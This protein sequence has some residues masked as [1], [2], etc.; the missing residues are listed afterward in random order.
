MGG[1]GGTKGDGNNRVGGVGRSCG[2]LEDGEGLW[3]GEDD[4]DIEGGIGSRG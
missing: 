4:L 2:S 1:G 3:I